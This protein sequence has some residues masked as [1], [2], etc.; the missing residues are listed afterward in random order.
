M[1]DDQ[2]NAVVAKLAKA[3]MNWNPVVDS[4]HAIVAANQV[5]GRWELVKDSDNGFEFWGVTSTSRF[6]GRDKTVPRAICKAIVDA[7]YEEDIPCR[8]KS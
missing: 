4:N 6:E 7:Q 8:G 3:Y 2:I 5:F 1:T